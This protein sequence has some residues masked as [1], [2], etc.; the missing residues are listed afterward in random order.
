M[1]NTTASDPDLPA[2][3]NGSGGWG[4][5]TS[6]DYTGPTDLDLRR[7]ALQHA[8]VVASPLGSASVLKA[9][10]EFFAFL[11]GA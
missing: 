11:K 2:V 9:A 4:W 3:P 1:A 10:A 7:E 8:C 5:G 6:E